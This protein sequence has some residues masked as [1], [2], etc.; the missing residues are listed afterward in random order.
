MKNV[1]LGI[2]YFLTAFGAL[3]IIT[4]IVMYM[5]GNIN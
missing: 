3:L 5:T 2:T 4:F 1:I